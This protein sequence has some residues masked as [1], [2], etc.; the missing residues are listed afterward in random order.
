M[1]RI[2]LL[3]FVI[4]GCVVKSPRRPNNESSQVEINISSKIKSFSLAPV[5]LSLN[6]INESAFPL[7]K[8][9]ETLKT[10]GF[11]YL[12]FPEGESADNYLWSIPP[13]E[14][15]NRTCFTT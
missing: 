1:K 9:K 11:K 13:Y 5:G 15:I 8:L 6:Q 10:S 4:Y 7:N 3:I 12:R 2:L 14:K